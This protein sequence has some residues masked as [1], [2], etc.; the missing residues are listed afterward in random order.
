MLLR[1][2]SGDWDSGCTRAKVGWG[3]VGAQMWE[4]TS[5]CLPHVSQDSWPGA[6]ELAG[7]LEPMADVLLRA[8]SP[9]FL[10]TPTLTAPC[11]VSS[12]LSLSTL[13][14]S[15]RPPEVF[16][17]PEGH[18]PPG[19]LP[20]QLQTIL[21]SERRHSPMLCL[22]VWC[23]GYQGSPTPAQGHHVFSATISGL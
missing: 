7:S 2:E 12:S 11:S 1:I 16:H 3:G 20:D 18:S 5:T 21:C 9:L 19:E 22:L 23:E 6:R 15:N 10:L 13:S 14:R 4:R 8:W 17:G